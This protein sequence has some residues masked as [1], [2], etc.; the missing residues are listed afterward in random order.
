MAWYT[1]KDTFTAINETSGT[2]VN[3]S[4]VPVEISVETVNCSGIVLFPRQH[5][6]FNKKIYAARAP[7]TI[8]TAFIG[9]IPASSDSSSND[10][11]SE[12]TDTSTTSTTTDTSATTST[13]N[14]GTINIGTINIGAVS[15]DS[16]VCNCSEDTG[17]FTEDDIYDA[18]KNWNQATNC[19][20]QN[21]L[22]TWYCGS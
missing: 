17:G 5:F 1:L 20:R 18:G 12:S 10:A 7:G 13:I 4:N 22:F 3:H 21:R 16:C 2:V 8:G 6:P 15:S 19:H 14:I 9:V 11:I